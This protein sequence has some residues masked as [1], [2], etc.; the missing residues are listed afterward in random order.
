VFCTHDNSLEGGVCW[1]YGGIAPPDYGAWAECYQG[2]EWISEVHFY[3]TQTGYYVGQTMDVYIW[4]DDGFGLPGDV[5]AAQFG[6]SPGP[7]GMWPEI[8][9][10]VLDFPYHVPEWHW[11]GFWG[12]WFDQQCGWFLMADE[13]GFS[14]CPAT[15]IAPGIGYPTGWQHTSVVPTFAMIQSLG[16]CKCAM[17]GPTPTSQ[18][19]WG[20][21][22]SLH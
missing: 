13:D 14:G 8:T 9:V 10:V 4:Q 19:T 22:K 21:I 15:K 2:N 6:V 12:E 5:A 17:E 1:Q 20:R 11:I 3:F 18:T 16:I 7:I